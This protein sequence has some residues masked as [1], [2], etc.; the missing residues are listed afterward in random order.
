MYMSRSTLLARPATH[1]TCEYPQISRF[2]RVESKDSIIVLCEVIRISFPTMY[3]IKQ[4]QHILL[5]SFP[6]SSLYRDL[7]QTYGDDKSE[8]CKVPA[9]V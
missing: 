7:E 1:S 4:L 9:T 6:W 8:H 2:A 5:R 3:S